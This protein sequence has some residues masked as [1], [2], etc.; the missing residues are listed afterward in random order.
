[1][2][3]ARA[4]VGETERAQAYAEAGSHICRDVPIIPIWFGRNHLAFGPGVEPAGSA[5]IDLFGD[6]VLRELRKS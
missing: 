2:N 1:M 3:K 6:P 4:A 5:R